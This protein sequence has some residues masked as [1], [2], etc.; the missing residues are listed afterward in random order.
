MAGERDGNGMGAA[1][2]GRERHG[3]ST[4][5]VIYELS[6]TSPTYMISSRG[7]S[8]GTQETCDEKR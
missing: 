4:A 3:R 2:H 8:L 7:I 6:L 5:F 1:W